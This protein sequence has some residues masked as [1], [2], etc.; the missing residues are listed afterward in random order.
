M[1]YAT[2]VNCVSR[3][4]NSRLIIFSRCLSR[5]EFREDGLEFVSYFL[6]CVRSHV[7]VHQT[8]IKWR[9][10]FRSGWG[11]K[12]HSRTMFWNVSSHS[13]LQRTSSVNRNKFTRHRVASRET[14]RDV[15]L[16]CDV[17]GYA[18]FVDEMC[19]N[20]PAIFLIPLLFIWKKTVQLIGCCHRYLPLASFFLPFNNN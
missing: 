11:E 9:G 3:H 4:N 17:K 15:S 18:G 1:N 8:F 6:V 2:I 19:F 7:G 12:G 13:A 10:V 20:Q 14:C 16:S 5:G